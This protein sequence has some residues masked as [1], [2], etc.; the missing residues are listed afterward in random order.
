MPPNAISEGC[1]KESEHLE[2][3][4]S[5]TDHCRHLPRMDGSL[6]GRKKCQESVH[7]RCCAVALQAKIM[8]LSGTA[9]AVAAAG[10][11]L[12]QLRL[13][14]AALQSDNERLLSYVDTLTATGSGGLNSGVRPLQEQPPISTSVCPSTGLHSACWLDCSCSSWF[15]K[16]RTG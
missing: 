15:V 8:R 4:V 14:N 16:V 1:V 7:N 10:E 6:W 11:L 3:V 12:E 13:E 9:P 2:V 5:G